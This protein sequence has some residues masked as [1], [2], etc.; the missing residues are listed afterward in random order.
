M[1]QAQIINSENNLLIG[2]SD[3]KNSNNETSNSEDDES[4]TIS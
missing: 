1:R 3:E 4:L 2:I